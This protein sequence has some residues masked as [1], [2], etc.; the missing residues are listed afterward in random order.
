MSITKLTQKENYPKG[1]C[2][3][4][5]FSCILGYEEVEKIPNFMEDGEINYYSK[6]REWLSA[7]GYEYTEIAKEHFDIS[8][9]M[10]LGY[11]TLVGKSLVNNCYHMIVGKSNVFKTEGNEVFREIEFVHDVSNVKKAKDFS[12]FE[13]EYVGFLAKKL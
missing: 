6:L 13:V 11:C 8:P 3:R 12:E 4:S 1:D 5:V 2:V 9:M 7:N 10:P